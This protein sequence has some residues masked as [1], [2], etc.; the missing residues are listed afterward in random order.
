ML[1]KTIAILL[2]FSICSFAQTIDSLKRISMALLSR[3][4]FKNI[5]TILLNQK[6]EK[7]SLQLPILGWVN[8]RKYKRDF[9]KISN[10]RRN[11]LCF[12]ARKWF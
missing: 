8:M 2:L 11:N 9:S 6:K 5:L 4:K 12:N 1:K 3:R 7:L 10:S